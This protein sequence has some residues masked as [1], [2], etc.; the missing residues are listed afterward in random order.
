MKLSVSRKRRKV[1]NWLSAEIETIPIFPQEPSART[2]LKHIFNYF[3]YKPQE[4]S[5][6]REGR[7]GGVVIIGS[8]SP[9]VER[10]SVNAVVQLVDFI[11]STY[12]L[13]YL[14]TA[15]KSMTREAMKAER[16]RG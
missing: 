16:G 14:Q 1:E 12:S 7:E 10:Q 8:C 13:L 9:V 2:V 3:V 11:G 4:M 5:M 15:S 6:A